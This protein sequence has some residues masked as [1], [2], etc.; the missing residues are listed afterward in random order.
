[1]A[2]TASFWR[3]GLGGFGALLV[4]IGVGRFGYP[5]LI[6]ALV[7][8]GWMSADAANLAGASNLLGYGIGA[9]AASRIIARFGAWRVT[10]LALIG[11][12]LSFLLCAVPMELVFF[13]ALRTLS[14]MTGG[15]LMIAV[16][17]VVMGSVD[18]S[19]R[20]RVNGLAFSGIGIGFLFAGTA[21]PWL[22]S[23]SL[24][25]AWLGLGAIL[26][27][28]SLMTLL[29]LPRQSRPLAA[30]ASAVPPPDETF[31]RWPYWGLLA[32][33]GCSAIGYVPHTIF[34]VDYV[35]RPLGHGLATGG[36]LWGLAGFVAVFAP[37]IGG[38]IAD[39]T[40]FGVAL[41]TF[42]AAMSIGAFMPLFTDNIV[43]LAI[44]IML[45]G[46]LMPG[47][48]SLAAGRTREIVGPQSHGRV[49]AVVTFVFAVTQA[50]G[51]Y[52]MAG[53]LALSDSYLMTFAAGGLIMT[54]GLLADILLTRSWRR[55]PVA[56]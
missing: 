30:S 49:W 46:G 32:I 28:A 34:F 12:T 4:G 38:F 55:K 17:P 7:E 2:G 33:Y 39:R 24:P 48:A 52:G 13:L 47:C 14:G 42:I 54:S 37:V 19:L 20:G 41:R 18:P 25:A 43:L 1:M 50:G 35:A 15:L 53:L 22:A 21:V 11:G 56:P 36:A 9:L 51:A 40:N 16:P 29:L 5:P 3:V 8:Q 27:I 26:F 6:P 23:T 31:S 45:T 10:W 44:S